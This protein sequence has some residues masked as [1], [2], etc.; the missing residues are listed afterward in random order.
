MSIFVGSGLGGAFRWLITLAIAAPVGILVVNTVG[1]L[2]MGIAMA[3][4][5]EGWKMF[6]LAGLLGGFTTMSSYSA[7]FVRLINDR[8]F[9]AAALYVLGTQVL[10]LGGAWAGHVVAMR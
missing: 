8:S 5:E 1:S 7:D 9:G 2:A 6:V 10:C 3:R 4:V